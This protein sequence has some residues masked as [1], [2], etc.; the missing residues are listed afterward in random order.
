MALT[1]PPPWSPPEPYPRRVH[2]AAYQRYATRVGRLPP[3][4]GRLPG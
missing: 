3:G 4:I 2:G 1:A